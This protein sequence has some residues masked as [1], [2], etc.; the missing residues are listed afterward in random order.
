MN[1]IGVE[2]LKRRLSNVIANEHISLSDNCSVNDNMSDQARLLISKYKRLA[3][4]RLRQNYMVHMRDRLLDYELLGAKDDKTIRLNGKLL[5]AN[6]A[7][8]M[9]VRQSGYHDFPQ[10]ELEPPE[11]MLNEIENTVFS[12]WEKS[13]KVCE[14]RQGTL[15]SADGRRIALAGIAVPL[16]LSCEESDFKSFWQVQPNQMRYAGFR[17]I[18]LNIPW[19]GFI[20]DGRLL[21]SCT[22]RLERAISLSGR[23]GM[24]VI[25]SFKPF[26][27]M[28]L[29][30]RSS[31]EIESHLSRLSQLADGNPYI[32][33]I[34]IPSLIFKDCRV[35]GMNEEDRATKVLEF[36][37][38]RND[39]AR[40]C[41]SM[42]AIVKRY[43]P[44]MPCFQVVPAISDEHDRN[45]FP[46]LDR[47]LLLRGKNVDGYA[48][49]GSPGQTS[50]R[51]ML[52]CVAYFTELSCEDFRSLS[53]SSE[54]VPGAML[55]GWQ[56]TVVDRN[57][58]PINDGHAAVISWWL[59]GRNAAIKPC[60]ALI[61]DLAFLVQ[62]EKFIYACID[63]LSGRF[64]APAILDAEEITS[65]GE[66]EIRERL[67]DKCVL[68][69][70]TGGISAKV[71]NMLFDFE[72]PVIFLWN[73]NND[74]GNISA[75]I[76]R[77]LIGT[78]FLDA[79][80][81]NFRTDLEI[82]SSENGIPSVVRRGNLWLFAK[83]TATEGLTEGDLNLIRGIV[84]Q[85]T[86]VK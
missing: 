58:F 18:R 20:D 42:A 83:R 60:V 78:F 53:F 9:L 32:A 12:I 31:G 62:N 73:A 13:G 80:A 33:G 66:D 61:A 76:P 64:L 59:R 14:V 82:I 85:A 22:S 29:Q 57:E 37:H 86:G 2:Y 45:D 36:I 41:E 5:G 46:R 25:L 1:G 67:S 39:Y 68:I 27:N 48:F 23:A 4:L 8:A 19:C 52:P 75:D 38:A 81:R 79:D 50:W 26:G 70:E 11:A 3:I 6:M 17:L 21:D 77:K 30:P 65:T 84:N 47:L 7:V 15:L 16:D 43:C 44:R 56:G 54:C 40:E 74:H 71:L 69:V 63:S 49:M 10:S 24:N 55:A 51:N 34:E 28:P 35:A 72:N